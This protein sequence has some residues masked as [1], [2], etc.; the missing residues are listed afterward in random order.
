MPEELVF[1]VMYFEELTEHVKELLPFIRWE[2]L[3]ILKLRNIAS[4]QIET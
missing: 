4:P 1:G 3:P 2:S